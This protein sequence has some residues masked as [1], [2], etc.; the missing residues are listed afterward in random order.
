[1]KSQNIVALAFVALSTLLLD[2]RSIL[3]VC[4]GER[5]QQWDVS[6]AGRCS[7]SLR[8]CLFVLG[9]LCSLLMGDILVGFKNI[10]NVSPLV[11]SN[12]INDRA[13]YKV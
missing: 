1:M 5:V 4:I 12:F 11:F 13:Y 2:P 8:F 7:C 9:L 3:R 10:K 6:P